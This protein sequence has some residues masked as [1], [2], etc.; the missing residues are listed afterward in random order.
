MSELVSKIDGFLQKFS[1]QYG[2]RVYLERGEEPPKGK[3][4]IVGKYGGR[5]YIDT[6]KIE[7]FSPQE[8][9]ERAKKLRDEA[10]NKKGILGGAES[11]VAE[12]QADIEE[13][14]GKWTF[15]ALFDLKGNRVRAKLIYV[16]DKFRG[17]KRKAWAVCD[18]DNKFTGEFVSYGDRPEKLAAKG[19]KEGTEDAPAVA[20]LKSYAPGSHYADILRT[21]EGYPDNAGE[22]A[23]KIKQKKVSAKKF[24]QP[25]EEPPLPFDKGNDLRQ[26]KQLDDLRSMRDASRIKPPGAPLPPSK[27]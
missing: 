26:A 27:K 10:R 5:Y 12:L 15:P 22:K 16:K 20:K 6:P 3:Q 14:D 25:K 18:K 23:T 1:Q 4:I 13:N 11:R 24:A 8:R 17:G 21:D 19:Y 2:N 7:T 9:T